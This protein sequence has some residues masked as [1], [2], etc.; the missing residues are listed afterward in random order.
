[1]IIYLFEQYTILLIWFKPL[2][3]DFLLNK[4]DWSHH[5]CAASLH[6]IP[7]KFKIDLKMLLL[8]FNALYGLR[9]CVLIYWPWYIPSP[10]SA[11]GA[12]LATGKSTLAVLTDQ[13]VVGGVL[14][15]PVSIEAVC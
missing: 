2:L 14:T 7:V 6:L 15:Q 4:E 8:T 9:L 13:S 3:P 11:D 10:G 12:L 5:P 1:M